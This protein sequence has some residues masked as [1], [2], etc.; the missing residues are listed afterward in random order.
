MGGA[1]DPP[2]QVTINVDNQVNVVSSTIVHTTRQGNCI[3]QI[4]M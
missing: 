4:H 1:F 3:I 2:T